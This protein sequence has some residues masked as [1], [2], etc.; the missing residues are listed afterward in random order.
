MP[1]HT[2]NAG[3]VRLHTPEGRTL[4]TWSTA[5]C[6]H[7]DDTRLTRMSRNPG[8]SVKFPGAEPGISKGAATA[9]QPVSSREKGHPKCWSS[10]R[11][12][13]V[14][15]LWVHS[16][17]LCCTSHQRTVTADLAEPTWAPCPFSSRHRAEI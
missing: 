1:S 5:C 8:G 10:P 9:P 12:A 14:N 11:R 4:V 13:T 15:S 6:N 17:G 16:Y 7:G 2:P 3:G